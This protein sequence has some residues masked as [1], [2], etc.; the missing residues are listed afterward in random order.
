MRTIQLNW[1]QIPLH[2]PFRISNGAIAVK[3]AIVVQYRE[4]GVT[5]WGEASPMAGA[6]Y[7][8]ETPESTWSALEK[9]ASADDP[10]SALSG[11]EGENFAKAGLAGAILD[12]DLRAC[13]VPLWQWL[14]SVN[15]P[16]PSGVAIGLYDTVEELLE[17]VELFWG[18]GYQRVK[19]KIQP[20]WD[21]EPVRRIREKFPTIP[22]MVDANAAY[23]L[24]DL[25]VFRELDRFGLMMYEQP[26]G[27]HALDQTAELARAVRTPVCADESA[28]SMDMLEQIIALRAAAIINIKIQRVGG[29]HAARQMHDRAM[30]AGLKCW[31]G[32]MPELGIASAEAVHLATLP[33][34]V[35]PADVEAS[36][37]WYTDD[38]LEPAIEIDSRGFLH[39][40]QFEVNLEKLEKYTIRTA[41]F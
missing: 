4:G 37:R 17:R 40:K 27:R 15:R 3:D 2:E 36:S 33:N 12:R 10:K 5:G 14:G 29:I 25:P 35:Y 13:G 38:L 24:S 26:L 18:H 21:V 34:F 41:K 16:V 39:P 30:Q 32:T 23:Q 8:Q 31:V 19:I 11:F 9:L 7:S 1:V 6:F 28:E 22:L 20:G